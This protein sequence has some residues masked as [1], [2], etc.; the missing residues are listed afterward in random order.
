MDSEYETFKQLIDIIPKYYILDSNNILKYS[1][2]IDAEDLLNVFCDP[3]DYSKIE[4]YTEIVKFFN[5]SNNN[6]IKLII[7][8]RNDNTHNGS[9]SIIMT[10]QEHYH[11]KINRPFYH[12]LFFLFLK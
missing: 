9:L 10:G 8:G 4:E 2:I 6:I 5:D 11:K 7:E 3:L 1:K 12:A